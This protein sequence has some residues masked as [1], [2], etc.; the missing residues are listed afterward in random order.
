MFKSTC[1][2]RFV[3]HIRGFVGSNDVKTGA[4]VR[5]RFRVS[6]ASC[7]GFFFPP[8]SESF[9]PDYLRQWACDVLVSFDESTVE[10]SHTYQGIVLPQ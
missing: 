5:A 9:L 8:P 3:A 1:C 4:S 10:S 2:N 6:N 7:C